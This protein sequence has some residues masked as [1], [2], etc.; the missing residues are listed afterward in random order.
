MR[1]ENNSKDKIAI[2]AVGYNR[3]QSMKRL[4][5][6]IQEA[7]YPN[8]DIPL[9]ISI[10]CSGD[11]ALYDY[12]QSFE[13]KHG[14]KYVNIQNE[15]LGLKNHIL[16]CGDLSEHFKA[17]VLL[18]DDIFV[19]EYFYKYIKEAVE[20]YYDEDR[21]GG[22]SLYQNEVGGS[23]PVC[24]YNDGSDTYLRQSVASWGE[25]WTDKQWSSFRAW[26]NTFNDDMFAQIDMPEVIKTWKRAWSKYYMA[27]LIKTNRYFVFPYLSHTT[28]FSEAGDHSNEGSTIGQVNL[29]CG[30]KNYTFKSYDEMTKYDIYLVNKDIYKWTELSENE[31][32]VD[33]RCSSKNLRRCR[34][35]MTPAILPFKVVK[36]YGMVMRPIELNIKYNIEGNDLFI[37]DT[38]DGNGNALDGTMPLSV[39]HYHLRLFNIRLARKYVTNYYWRSIKRKLK[40]FK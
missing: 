34:Y 7:Q 2:V 18:E 10:D 6:S 37:Y 30:A 15:R 32:C 40:I 4:L 28:C 21:I 19:S 35:I 9:V 31:L 38:I 5:G 36:T 13:W 24:F 26:L 23:L 20:F 16:Q 39:A 11:M 33:W 25:C 27:Y 29:M 1:I 12:V 3:L 8:D 17:I 22:I 14:T